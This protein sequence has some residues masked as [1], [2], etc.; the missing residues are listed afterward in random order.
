[1][2]FACLQ[3][4]HLILCVIIRFTSKSLLQSQEAATAPT[5]A[6]AAAAAAVDVANGGGD[7]NGNGFGIDSVREQ[8]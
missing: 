5:A 4:L 6:A 2:Y 1:M 7:G 3:N 8:L